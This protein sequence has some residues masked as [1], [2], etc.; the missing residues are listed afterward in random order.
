VK[1][2]RSQIGLSAGARRR[3]VAGA[4][5]LKEGEGARLLGKV[6][7][8]IDDVRTTGATAE[9]CAR[10]LAAH[11]VQAVH[12]LSVARVVPGEEEII[13]SK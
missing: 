11:G 3:N 8:L 12:V 5:Q 13:S 7:V 1:R 6:V 10:V 4:F 2:T 9:A